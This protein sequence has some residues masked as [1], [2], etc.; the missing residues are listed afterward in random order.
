MNCA[1]CSRPLRED[2]PSEDFC[3]WVCQE[4]W[5]AKGAKPLEPF[6]KRSNVS[7]QYDWTEYAGMYDVDINHPTD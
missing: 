7:F 1:Q 4:D 3:T 5:Y 2:G 6:R